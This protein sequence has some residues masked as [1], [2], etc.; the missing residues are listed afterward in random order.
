MD[1]FENLM[2]S[3]YGEKKRTD[4][5]SIPPF[6]T[7]IHGLD[8]VK[9]G[10]PRKLVYKLIASSAAAIITTLLVLRYID[11]APPKKIPPTISH[12]L[13]NQY[14]TAAT[15]RLLSTGNKQTYIWQW[16]SPTDELLNLHHKILKTN[17]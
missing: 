15:D 17:N 8:R 11:W 10:R 13:M 12:Q 6:D 4:E 3:L 14:T 7:L 1:L 9:P 16:K 2:K 5:R